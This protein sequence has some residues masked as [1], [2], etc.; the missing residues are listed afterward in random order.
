[1]P[2]PPL[3]GT[4][5]AC[6]LRGSGVS[7]TPTPIIRRTTAAESNASAPAKTR[8]RNSASAVTGGAAKFVWG[9]FWRQGRPLAFQPVTV[10]R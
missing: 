5:W 10:P 9:Y 2:M 7:I 3:F 1:M 8:W 6:A 4:G